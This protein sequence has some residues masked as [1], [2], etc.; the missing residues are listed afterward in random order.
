MPKS[1]ETEDAY[2]KEYRKKLGFTS[3]GKAKG[4][5]GAKDII[6][7]I[8]F[9]YIE[10]L[11]RRL[12][13]MVDRMNSVVIK[14]VVATMPTAF[15]KEFIDRP[16]SIMKKNG[17]LPR[18][19]NL[20]RR[21]EQVY[22]NWMRGYVIQSFFSKAIDLIFD[23]DTRRKILIGDDD[24]KELGTFKKTPKADLE[25]ELNSGEKLRLEI[26]AGFTG[27]NDIK[28]HKVTEAKRVFSELGIHTIA[29]HFDLFDGKA[30]F[31]K[32]DEIDEKN[33]GWESRPQ[34]EGQTVLSISP[35]HFLWNMT[36]SPIKYKDMNL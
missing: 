24:F 11:N 21:P 25:L 6:P 36:D 26:Q 16:F 5:F 28:K 12:Y 27:T 18:L 30:A 34:M 10:L 35:K 22:F 31:L 33:P 4:F 23:V 13:E 8:D 2:S 7:T 32:L 20:G 3:E 14:E 29:V 9:E 19:N 17:I 1:K 15:K